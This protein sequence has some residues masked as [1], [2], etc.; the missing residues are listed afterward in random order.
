MLIQ[1]FIKRT[2]FH[3]RSGGLETQNK[4]LS[5]GL[6]KLGYKV[7]VISPK[8]EL[9]DAEKIENGV[10]YT[11][12]DCWYSYSQGAKEGFVKSSWEKES[13]EYYKKT[14]PNLVI[15][16][17]SAG[18][19]IIKLKNRVPVIAIA[20]GTILREFKTFIKKGGYKNPFTFVKTAQYVAREYLFKQRQFINK[21]DFVVTVSEDVK[22]DLLKETGVDAKKVQVI[23][24]GVNKTRFLKPDINNNN[25]IKLIYIG[26]LIKEK[27][28]GF[29]ISAISKLKEKYKDIKLTIVGDGEDKQYFE[30]LVKQL[31]LADSVNFVGRVDYSEVPSLLNRNNIFIHPSVRDEGFPMVMLEAVTAGLPIIATDKGGTRNVVRSGIN[32]ILLNPEE[33]L[34][35]QIVEGV[36]FIKDGIKLKDMSDESLKIASEFSF[37]KVINQYDQIIK[38]L[39]K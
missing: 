25:S 30:N 11:F 12:L 36:S 23:Y 29:A 7:N 6:V 5:E 19:S 18:F 14:N 13:L 8:Y 28:V 38:A 15:S 24:V 17:S 35:Q 9:D 34:E 37:D 22:K 33:N 3:K 4:E 20:H 16:Q 39:T 27:G 31:N 26:V 2:H 32:G 1:I 21:A 10:I